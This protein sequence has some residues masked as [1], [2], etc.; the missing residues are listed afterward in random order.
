MS[1]QRTPPGTA[2]MS[3]SGSVSG[4]T[5]NPSNYGNED[6]SNITIRKRN[7]RTEEQDYKMEFEDFRSDILKLLEEF[8]K[9]QNEN[10]N[11]IKE[12]ISGIRNEVKIIKSAFEKLNN[13]FDQ[14]DTEIENIKTTNS[15]NQ[16]KIK[17]IESEIIEIKKA[18]NTE[19]STLK[20]LPLMQENLYLE[21]KD[22]CEREKNIVIVGILEKNDSNYKTRQ[23]YDDAEV[24]KLL[25]SVYESCPKP[26]KIVRLGKYEPN[27]NRPIKAYF[28]DVNTVRY[29]LRN[30]TK[31]SGNTHFYSDQTPMQKQY[32][33]SLKK[34]IKQREQ[35]GEKD[36]IIKYKKGIPT[37]IANKNNQ[38]N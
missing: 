23:C 38:K 22:R 36:L 28:S 37:I 1:L 33:D 19:C 4:S 13:K 34:E 29:L 17:C 18:Q 26:I 24:M 14:I 27:K 32:L 31:L 16:E 7:N 35:S 2:L 11:S 10:M 8:T 3:G 20:P 12:E 9:K 15:K 30:K 5:P 25:T 21:I 6:Y